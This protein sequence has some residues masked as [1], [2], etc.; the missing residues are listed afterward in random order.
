MDEKVIKS[1]LVQ[2][3]QNSEFWDVFIELFKNDW[4]D[5]HVKLREIDAKDCCHIAKTQGKLEYITQVLEAFQ[6]VADY[7]VN[8]RQLEEQIIADN[9][10]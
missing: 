2:R 9:D 10:Y 6:E 1:K 3:F 4:Q 7:E 8:L 5:L